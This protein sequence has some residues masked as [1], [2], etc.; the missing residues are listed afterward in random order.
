MGEKYKKHTRPNR[1][2]DV[3]AIRRYY[4]NDSGEVELTPHQEEKKARY[5]TVFSLLRKGKVNVQIVKYLMK[6]F[7]IS[8]VRAYADIKESIKVYADLRKAEKE[9][10]RWI[11]L[12]RA[13]ATYQRAVKAGNLKQQ[14]AALANQIKITGVDREDP[15]LPDFDKLKPGIV[16]VAIP[17]ELEE[18]ISAALKGGAVNLN[19]FQPPQ[20]IE[21]IDHEEV[22]G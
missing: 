14:N 8:E 19:N 4:E 1:L 9:G 5:L 22:T 16:I 10:M 15:E 17:Q 3:E 2:T 13:E 18:N 6:V 11:L 21:D 12:D 7:D 20:P